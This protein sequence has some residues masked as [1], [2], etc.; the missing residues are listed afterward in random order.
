MRVVL[1]L[2]T[3]AAV[4]GCA[5]DMTAPAVPPE[6]STSLRAARTAVGPAGPWRYGHHGA[7]GLM[8]ARRLP[9]N[10]Q[11]TDAQRAQI[12]TLMRAFRAA[13]QSE[14]SA[15]RVSMQQLR[16]ARGQGQTLSSDQR[17]A[18]FQQTTPARQRLMVD[19]RT[20]ARQIQNVLTADQQAWLAAH[21]P[22]PCASTEA[23]R[24]RFARHRVPGGAQMR[25]PS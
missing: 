6:P 19:E 25:N 14:L 11:L 2:M 4:S 9:A 17:R 22:A 15:M 12:R 5:Q 10:L 7:M 23:C 24:A 16:T 3:A 18:L 8:M 1:L 20:L 21:R 13:H